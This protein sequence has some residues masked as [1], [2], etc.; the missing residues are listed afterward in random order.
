[1]KLVLAINLQIFFGQN[2]ILIVKNN[3]NINK[4]LSFG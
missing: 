1:M 3:L 2:D 4:H